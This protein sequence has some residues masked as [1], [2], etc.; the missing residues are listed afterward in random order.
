MEASEFPEVHI[1]TLPGIMLHACGGK[2]SE[3]ENIR[4]TE[5]L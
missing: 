5:A 2:G 1:A 4:V 3:G